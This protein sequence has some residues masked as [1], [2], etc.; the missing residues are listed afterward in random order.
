MAHLYD[1]E[2]R[3]GLTKYEF[4][5]QSLKEDILSG[6]LRLGSKLPSKRAI[7]QENGISVR[8]VMQ[9]YEQLVMEGY[10]QPKERSGYFVVSNFHN[11]KSDQNVPYLPVTPEFEP[12]WLVDF[13][14]NSAVVEKFPFTLWVRAIKGAISQ[15]G[16][17]LIRRGDFLGSKALR[18]EVSSYLIRTRDVVANP[19]CLVIAS[20]IEYLYSRLISLLPKNF[21]YAVETPG[22]RKIPRI[23]EDIGVQWA[24]VDMDEEGISISSLEASG[25]NVVH[26]SPEHHYPLGTVMSLK[27]RQELL[28][29]LHARPNRFIIEDDYDCEFRYRGKSIPALAGLDAEHRVIYMNTF[30]KTMSPGIRISYMLMP[31]RLIERYVQTT[32]FFSNSSSNLDQHA[33]ALFIHDG[34]FE[35]HVNRLRKYFRTQGGLLMDA[36]E[37]CPELPVEKIAGIETGTHLLVK[38]RTELSDE[39]IAWEASRRK[40]HLSMLSEFCLKDKKR[41]EHVLVLN[42]P[43]LC[44]EGI[45]KAVRELSLVFQSQRSV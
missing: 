7:A 29:W 41:Y 12:K 4:L 33:L 5:Y 35:R 14:S 43:T 39:E 13:A 22:Y 32:N 31:E 17:N 1:F 37:R 45:E 23:F 10:V 16:R 36:I 27:R 6:R 25:A 2:N 30:S 42:F 21:I 8:T 15:Y 19:D 18:R 40:I 9:A 26:V 20:S 11:K 38:L 44:A 24:C 34:Y 28:E 3:G